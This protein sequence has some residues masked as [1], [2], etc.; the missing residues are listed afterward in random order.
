MVHKCYFDI[1][2]GLAS[3]VVGGKRVQPAGACVQSSS[4]YADYYDIGYGG[5]FYFGH[6]FNEASTSAPER[7]QKIK[8]FE[9]GFAM[10][11]GS[12]NCNFFRRDSSVGCPNPLDAREVYGVL[13]YSKGKKI[14]LSIFIKKC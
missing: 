10:A 2:F 14:T 3:T 6:Y 11:S 5:P 4:N 1:R 8:K 7:I 12:D 9:H 13:D